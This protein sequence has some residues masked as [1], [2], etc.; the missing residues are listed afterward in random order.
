MAHLG[1]VLGPKRSWAEARLPPDQLWSD[2]GR[3]HHGVGGAT[4]R[5]HPRALPPSPEPSC[6]AVA[7]D[8]DAD[9]V[10]AVLRACRA[11]LD[12][13]DATGAEEA[14]LAA[15]TSCGDGMVGALRSSPEY[16][17]T[18]REVARIWFCVCHRAGGLG[19]I[20]RSGT[21]ARVSKKRGG[22]RQTVARTNIGAVGTASEV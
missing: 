14:L 9:A 17:E 12:L 5:A 4:A 1:D 7:A 6:K 19:G 22:G 21:Q 2:R 10:A 15:L 13:G 20:S 11:R 3:R 18:L 8:A 16:A